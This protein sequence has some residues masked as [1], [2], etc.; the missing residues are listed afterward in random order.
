MRIEVV[1]DPFDEF[2]VAFVGG[3]L[4]GFEEFGIT[5]GAATIL[6][7]TAATDFDQTRIEYAWLG[8]DEA[9]D[10]D[11]V[12]PAVAEVIEYVSFFIPTSSRIS[13]SRALRASRNSPTPQSA[14][15]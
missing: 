11:R 2:G 7:R 9:L 10:L 4:D 12:L 15:G 13:L 3:V 6:G 5:P 14:S 1:A 8:I